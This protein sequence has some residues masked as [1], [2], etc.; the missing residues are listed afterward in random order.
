LIYATGQRTKPPEVKFPPE[1][2][3]KN[4]TRVRKSRIETEHLCSH[5]RCI[6]TKMTISEYCANRA[7]SVTRV[8]II[9]GVLLMLGCSAYGVIAKAHINSWYVAGTAD[10]VI[11]TDA[12]TLYDSDPCDR[13]HMP[14]IGL[15]AHDLQIKI[16]SDRLHVIAI[17]CSE[18][19]PECFSC[20]FHVSHYGNPKSQA[21]TA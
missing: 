10:L 1:T 12:K 13:H 3:A 16:V 21:K 5:F 11:F 18:Q 7:R 19:L 20:G 15:N 4:A 2:Q 9:L 6:V 8:T 17:D 14:K